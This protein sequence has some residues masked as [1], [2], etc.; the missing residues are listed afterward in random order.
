MESEVARAN[1]SLSHSSHRGSVWCRRRP[2]EIREQE[3]GRLDGRP[4]YG[5]RSERPNSNAWDRWRGHAG[6]TAADRRY[7]TLA[8][9]A[10][11]G[12]HSAGGSRGIRAGAG[13]STRNDSP[14][15]HASTGHGNRRPGR[16]LQVF[17]YGDAAARGRDTDRLDTVRV[18]PPNTMVTWKEPA[19]LLMNNNL[20]VVVSHVMRRCG[21]AFVT[22]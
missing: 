10:V 1:I 5:D 11:D 16:N 3:I 21:T 9:N 4:R 12:G 19:S 17:I 8:T 20:A 2:C 7:H 14:T 13:A 22:R 15:I 18:A 6:D